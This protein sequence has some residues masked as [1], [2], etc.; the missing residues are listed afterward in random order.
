MM[1]AG[2][3]ILNGLAY[4]AIYRAGL[5]RGFAPSLLL[6]ARDL[7]LFIPLGGLFIWLVRRQ[8]Y[9]GDWTLLTVAVLLFGVGQ[10]MQYRLFTDPEYTAERRDDAVRR[11]RQAKSDTIRQQNINDHYDAE[12]KRVLFGDPDYQIPMAG[13]REEA[14][15]ESGYWTLE[16]ILTS[17]STL[18]PLL[19]LACFALSFVLTG[20]DLFLIR[21]QRYSLLISLL[22][23]LPFI[24]LGVQF[25]TAGKF[26]GRTTPWEPVKVTFL[27][28]FAGILADHYRSLSRTRWG[29]PS[30]RFLLPFLIIA[31]MPVASFLAL[32][33]FGQLL[34]FLGVYLTLYLVAVRRLQQVALA[35]LL[36]GVLLG[37]TLLARGSYRILT[38]PEEVGG[39][40]GEA[41]R[42][43]LTQRV[44]DALSR[45]VPA[46]IHQRFHLWLGGGMPPDPRDSWWWAEQ[47]VR[48]GA[49]REL[50][51]IASL[52]EVDEKVNE[53]L[54]YNQ[55]AFQPSQALFGISAG[56]LLG[57]GLGKGYPESVPIADSDFIYAALAE[58]L[59]VLGGLVVLASFMLLVTAGMRTAIGAPDMFTKLLA[60]GV[61]AFLCLQALVNI[62]GVIRML[63]MTGITLPFV[64]HGGWSLLTTFWML[65]ML[66]AISHRNQVVGDQN[67]SI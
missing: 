17:L 66:M 33:D 29:I 13:D 53:E 35:V 54:W 40:I 21:L 58:E 30:W 51:T 9:A 16:R 34:V 38:A 7:A 19:A 11:A 46:R 15:V 56:R 45:G 52:V 39:P 3:F 57:K 14:A 44:G 24:L 64:S 55:Y 43:T 26:I 50:R 4:L 37:A 32:S 27:I 6:A 25:S 59:G 23:I 20:R 10:F 60:A 1:V 41:G 63:P 36:V 18:V 31:A 8:R 61:T 28:S 65:G 12:K 62:G 48:Y 5:D 49:D 22:T 67:P 2:L 47:Q 42:A